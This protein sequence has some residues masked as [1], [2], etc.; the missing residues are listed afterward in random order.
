MKSF[1]KFLFFS[2]LISTAWA[3]Q[4][5]TEITN[6]SFVKNELETYH[7]SGEYKSDISRT[8]NQALYYLRFRVNQNARLEHP[9]KL[10]IVLDI[11][12]TSL[13]NY[14]DLVRL[15]FGGTA[16]EVDLAEGAGH[17]PAIKETLALFRYAKEKHV[18]V[19]FITGRHPNIRANTIM[20]L[21]AAGFTKWDGL[22]M[23]PEDY[24]QQS[25]I[26]FKSGIRKTIAAR[27]YD[28]VLNLGDQESDLKGG[29]SDM[30]FKLPNPFYFIG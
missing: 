8:V 19:F 27:G 15:N 18:A 29:F 13:S 7:D 24:D 30:S 23:K 28:I 12:E 5:K 1:L 22:Y 2:L 11:D 6:L 20:N 14:N 21:A 17:D 25:V 4:K 10:A 9:K 26:P 3:S 16:K